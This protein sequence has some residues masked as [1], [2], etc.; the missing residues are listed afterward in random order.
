MRLV[1]LIGFVLISIVLFVPATA[2]M[3]GGGLDLSWVMVIG[4][5]F[6]E[7]AQWGK[8]IIF[9]YG[10][11][12]FVYTKYYFN[13][14]YSLTIPIW[15]FIISVS[16]ILAW[17]CFRSSHSKLAVI[18]FL[19]FLMYFP[20]MMDS[21]YLLLMS[22]P[23]LYT[24]FSKTFRLPVLLLS[25]VVLAL[26]SLV[27]TTFLLFSLG[28]L[29]LIEVYFIFH[30]RGFLY[31][32]LVFFAAY[33]SFYMAS[34]QALESW[35]DY[36]IGAG[37]VLVGYGSS[38]SLWGS[39]KEVILF[40]LISALFFLQMFFLLRSAN[41]GREKKVISICL[42]LALI[43]ISFKQ[44]FVRHDLH[45]L[46]AWGG[47][48]AGCFILFFLQRRQKSSPYLVA[49][50]LL[51]VTFC[52]LFRVSHAQNKTIIAY[53]G[54]DILQAHTRQVK[55]FFN[56]VVDTKNEIDKAERAYHNAIDSLASHSPVSNIDGSIDIIDNSQGTLIAAGFDYKPRPVFQE[57]STYT[58]ALQRINR[59]YFENQP[60]DYV[61]FRP[62]SIDGRLPMLAEA[63]SW[64]VFWKK[65]YVHSLY[66]DQLL[67]KRSAGSN[68]LTESLIEKRVIRPG[69]DIDISSKG[70]V[71]AKIKFEKS[72]LG[73]LYS[74]AYKLPP[75][76]IEYT[77]GDSNRR[78]RIIPGISEEGFYISPLI[79][80]S[81][82]LVTQ[83]AKPCAENR[84][85]DSFSIELGGKSGGFFYSD[86]TVELYKHELD[87]HAVVA[88][89]LS[90]V[91]DRRAILEEMSSS[92]QQGAPFVMIEGDRLLAHAPSQ[93]S[94]FVENKE[95]VNFKYGIRA[96]AANKME[97]V[98][99]LVANEQKEALWQECV[100][101]GRQSDA[102][103]EHDLTLDL[104][105]YNG[106]LYFKNSCLNDICN[107]AWSYWRD[108]RVN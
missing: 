43:F 9:T 85:P 28:I 8:D 65:Y 20:V 40:L 17:E 62:G 3:P 7:G 86:I 32:T 67:L 47:L 27:K 6:S 99:F 49:G 72:L 51:T 83:L 84:C 54:E 77:T 106:Q 41:L 38:M 70:W 101:G 75:V 94:L 69:Q 102:E 37:E 73:S 96:G 57:Y 44:G 31:S 26:L 59:A 25:I 42:G 82:S 48:M 71:F 16:A 24:L 4:K 68:T 29:L 50:L 91:I 13:D 45:S 34:G 80:S 58:P 46:I 1:L 76:F 10:P 12:G 66:A 53:I 61:L 105:G 90:A 23:L 64:P 88:S 30:R 81:H 98:C 21:L 18:G 78:F 92:S 36:I 39:R 74:L 35:P 107:F 52:G 19:C 11:Y 95:S 2:I 104:T 33:I 89:Q 97:G 100:R 60:P 56:L 103:I 63:A 108:V 5:G 14:F 15:V 22:L 55:T 93:V 87:N 79:E